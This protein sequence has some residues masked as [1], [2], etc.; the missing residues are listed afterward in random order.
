MLFLPLTVVPSAFFEE[1]IKDVPTY[2]IK[3]SEPAL[4]RGDETITDSGGDTIFK[5]CDILSVQFHETAA[6]PNYLF[7]TIQF[8]DLRWRWRVERTVGWSFD[9][10]SYFVYHKVW[11]LGFE[12]S[13]L[14]TADSY[15]AAEFTYDSLSGQIIWKIPKESIGNP[16]PG[17]ILYHTH[18]FA[19]FEPSYLIGGGLVLFE[20]V[21]PDTGYGNTYIIQY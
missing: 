4:Q 17:N 8:Q 10:T 2:N 11:T 15:S 7:I 9:D 18:A 16:A 5:Y 12:W 3:V 21:A 6:D 20:D 13:R 14:Y 1:K 19:G